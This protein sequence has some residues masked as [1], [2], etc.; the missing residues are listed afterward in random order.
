MTDTLLDLIPHYGLIVL[1]VTGFLACLA[2]PIPS[3]MLVLAAGSFAATGDLVLWHVFAVAFVSY[4]LGDQTAFGIAH[5]AG[6]PFL[7]WLRKSPRMEPVISKSQDLIQRRGQ[8]AVVISHT[9]LSPTCPY[10]SYLCGAGGM[11]WIRFSFAAIGGAF[12]WSCVYVGLGF[13]FATQLTLVA[14][15]LSNFFGVIMAGTTIALC[16]LWLHGKWKAHV[17]RAEADTDTAEVVG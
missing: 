2:I 6:A 14:G 1:F 8:A 12:I 13:V 3:S 17:E 9:I 5:W 10:V 16:V 4:V 15:I 7:Q 11:N